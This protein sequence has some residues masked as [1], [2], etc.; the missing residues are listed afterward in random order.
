MRA[1]PEL[2]RLSLER[3]YGV[4]LTGEERPCPEGQKIV[5]WPSELPESRAVSLEVLVGWRS[6]DVTASGGAYSREFVAAMGRA[7][8]GQ[9]ESFRGFLRTVQGRSGAV[10]LS[11]NGN[12]V[13][14]ESDDLWDQ[15]WERLS[16]QISRHPFSVMGNSSKQVADAVI[17]WISLALGSVLSLVPLEAEDENARREGAIKEI[18][19]KRYERDPINR[20]L[21][22]EIHGSTC[23]ACGF[24]FGDVYGE[25][26]EGFI[27]VH[28]V[29]PLSSHKGIEQV[30]NPLTALVPL[31]CNCHAMAHRRNPPYRVDELRSL[32]PRLGK[33]EITTNCQST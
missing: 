1:E 19:S 3:R 6:L 22:L 9:R 4:G 29:D 25:I 26:G 10:Q 13:S 14:F 8:L 21:C 15:T 33:A 12:M 27:E 32:M 2:I 18:L 11:L 20:A 5:F 31:C 23:M 30:I 17:P 7:E 28:H 24:S 16:I